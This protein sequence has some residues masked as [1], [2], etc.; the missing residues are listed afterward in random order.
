MRL[1]TARGLTF[2]VSHLFI[3]DLDEVTLDLSATFRALRPSVVS[4]KPSLIKIG[5]ACDSH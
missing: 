1:P 3:P 5:I 2:P 4:E